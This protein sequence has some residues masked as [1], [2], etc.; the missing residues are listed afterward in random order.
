M[1]AASP[2]IAESTENAEGGKIHDTPSPGEWPNAERAT[3]RD[4]VNQ[5]SS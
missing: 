1:S 5:A 3:G 4:I 2:F